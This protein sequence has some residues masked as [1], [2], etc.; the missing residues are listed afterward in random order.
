MI[1]PYDFINKNCNIINSTRYINI[2]GFRCCKIKTIIKLI[3][4]KRII[5]MLFFDTEMM[6]FRKHILSKLNLF[7]LGIDNIVVVFNVTSL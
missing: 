3:K 2:F 7:C 4:L 1:I 6:F 5:C